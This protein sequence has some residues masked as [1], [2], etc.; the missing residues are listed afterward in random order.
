[1]DSSTGYEL[2]TESDPAQKLGY[3]SKNSFSVRRNRLVHRYE[4]FT[5]S[6][7]AWKLE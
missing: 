3:N 2:F 5:E 7:T 1:M 6:D 4:L